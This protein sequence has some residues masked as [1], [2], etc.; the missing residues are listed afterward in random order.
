MERHKDHVRVLV[1]EDDYFIATSIT[2]E[3]QH[4]GLSVVG[5]VGAGEDALR[6]MA[7]EPVDFAVLDI[8]LDGKMVFPVAAALRDAAIPFIFATGFDPGVIPPRFRDVPLH[9]KPYRA[10]NLA[11]A[12]LAAAGESARSPAPT[13]IRSSNQILQ[14]LA[15]DDLAAIMP[16]A[17][18][19]GPAAGG[20]EDIA[21]RVLFPERGF[22]S[23]SLSGGAGVTIAVVG[24]EG[25][26]GEPITH[27]G[28]KLKLA[29]TWHP[30]SEYV[31]VP[32]AVVASVM[33]RSPRLQRIAAQFRLSFVAQLAWTSEAHATLTIAENLA[34]WIAMAH[35]RLGSEIKVTHE[36]L[37][38]ALGVRRAGVTTALHVLEGERWLKS[39]RGRI[40]VLDRAALE[41]LAGRTYARIATVDREATAP[42]LS[43][44][45][46]N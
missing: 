43:P 13:D 44:R 18:R 17:L 22:C 39:T 1:V 34:R 19:V 5:P 29:A 41:R 28:D 36:D 32:S 31:A 15:E 2:E 3:L 46:L 9:A 30:G 6:L 8:N 40:R 24:A 10:E 23:L 12:A 45:A 16:H 37:S 35:D 11:N 27:D 21:G 25:L 38:R 42:L 7:A 14:L 26:L 33:T 20:Q 4:R